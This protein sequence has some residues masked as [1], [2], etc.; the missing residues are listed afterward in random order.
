MVLAVLRRGLW[1]RIFLLLACDGV[2]YLGL[3]CQIS[4]AIVQQD[5]D[6]TGKRWT[7]KTL[8]FVVLRV[9]R[10]FK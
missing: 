10:F 1:K 7:F 3:S 6:S 2:R 5:V 4:D 9:Q 8:F